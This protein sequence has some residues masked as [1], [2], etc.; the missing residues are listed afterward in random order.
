MTATFAD[1]LALACGV[2]GWFYLFYSRAAANL[3]AV[4]S[5]S[6]NRLRKWLRKVCG[7]SL[8]ILGAAF[9]AG[10]NSVDEHR[11]PT[12]FL[13]VWCGTFLLL[14]LILVLVAVDILFT[15]KMRREKTQNA[16]N[17]T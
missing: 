7:A 8:V 1:I 6:R 4:E 5:S 2:A 15:L 3:S 11:T 16:G 17:H 14:L 10:F 13:A 9:F 12:A